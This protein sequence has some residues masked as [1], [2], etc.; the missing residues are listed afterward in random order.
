MIETLEEQRNRAHQIKLVERKKLK[1]AEDLVKGK[2]S[3]SQYIVETAKLYPVPPIVD[4]A[5]DV[6]NTRAIEIYNE[7]ERR[8]P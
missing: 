6:D 4:F 7:L 1:L 3:G 5:E 2:I 8:F